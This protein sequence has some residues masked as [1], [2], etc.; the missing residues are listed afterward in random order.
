MPKFWVEHVYDV[1][2]TQKNIFD[3][4]TIRVEIGDKIHL[5]VLVLIWDN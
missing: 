3:E 4:P 2:W 1:S 5:G